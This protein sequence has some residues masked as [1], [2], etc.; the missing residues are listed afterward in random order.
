MKTEKYTELSEKQKS[1]I[2][3]LQAEC[4]APEALENVAFLSNAINYDRTI[5]CFYLG[6]ERDAL[7]AF[8]TTFLPERGEA[9]I[10]AFTRPDKRQD[11]RFAELL[12]EAKRELLGHNITR[13][14]F[15]VEP[16]SESGRATLST[17]GATEWVR[18]EYRMELK[19]AKRTDDSLRIVDLDKQNS[20]VFMKIT[21]QSF[22]DEKDGD[23]YLS[24][25]LS[26]GGR[27]G[28][29]A[30]DGDRP[31][32]TFCFE[33]KEGGDGFIYGVV[34]TEP[35]RGQGYGRKM[36]NAAVAIGCEKTSTVRLDVDSFNPPAFELYKK[37]GFKIVFQVDYYLLKI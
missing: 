7:V 12:N 32:G 35:L 30:Y 8:L 20:D 21:C 26:E 36:M 33:Q 16:K 5:P 11:G 22:G 10:V 14:V 37:I 18:S 23:S 13:I 34:I 25:L 1:E 3:A 27:Q 31:V 28:Y 4:Y 2:K 24:A 17:L 19:G 9:E 15:A 29:I 6:Y